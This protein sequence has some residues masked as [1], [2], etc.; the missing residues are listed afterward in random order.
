MKFMSFISG[1]LLATVLYLWCCKNISSEPQKI[2]ADQ[3]VRGDNC[4]N[5]FCKSYSDNDLNGTLSAQLIQDLSMAYK[6]DAGK[7]NIN[8]QEIVREPQEDALSVVFNINKIKALIYLMESKRC[9][10]GCSKNEQL[11]IRYYY[12]KYPDDLGPGRNKNDGLDSLDKSLSNKHSLVMVPTYKPEGSRE[13]YDYN[14]WASSPTACYPPILFQYA[15][16]K[17]NFMAIEPTNGGENHGGVGP[18]P[19]PGT[20]PT[21]NPSY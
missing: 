2:K 15:N 4:K 19:K 8:G 18:P 14:P 10:D 9:Y 11:G 6:A 5:V 16:E 12:I 17:M 13:W 20:F 1:F 21:T 3:P 7:S